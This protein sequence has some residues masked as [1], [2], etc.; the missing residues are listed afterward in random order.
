[1]PGPGGDGIAMDCA[2]NIVNENSK[3]G[4]NAAFGGPDGKTLIAVGG[5][6]SVKI[7]QMTVPGFP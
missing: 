5:G 1:M 6:T 3:Y 4:T 2:G 7:I